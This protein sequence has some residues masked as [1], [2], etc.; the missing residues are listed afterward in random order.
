M[1]VVCAYTTQQLMG[2]GNGVRGDKAEHIHCDDQTFRWPETQN[3]R[4]LNTTESSLD[5][6]AENGEIRGELR[7][8]AAVLFKQSTLG[9]MD[10]LTLGYSRADFNVFILNSSQSP[11]CV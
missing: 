7:V 3:L 2:L 6:A 5:M 10:V 1:V 9:N 4:A 11:G 8:S